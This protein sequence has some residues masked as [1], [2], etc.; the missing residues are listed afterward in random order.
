M[1]KTELLR[2]LNSDNVFRHFQALRAAEVDEEKRTI[3]LSFSSETP[4]ARS[5][6]DEVLGHREGE[7]SFDRL[8][9]G[10]A[11]LMDHNGRDQIGVVLK[12]WTQ[13]GIGRALVKFGRSARAQEIFQD[14]A[15]GIRT[16]ISV[17]Y[18]INDY[19]KT[20]RSGEAPLYRMNWSPYEISIVSVPADDSIGIGR[21][22]NGLEAALPE[23]DEKSKTVLVSDDDTGTK[24]PK[25][26]TKTQQRNIV[27]MAEEN[28]HEAT[29][30]IIALCNQFGKRELKDKALTEGWPIERVKDEILKEQGAQRIAEPAAKPELG[31]GKKDIEN[32]SLVRAINEWV[33]TGTVTGLEG[34]ASAAVM[35][36]TG[37]SPKG[38]FVPFDIQ[39]AQFGTRDLNAST[40]T[41]GGALVGT[42]MQSMIELLY[43]RMAVVGLGARTLSGLQ[44]NIAIPK[45][46]GGAIAYWLAEG[47]AVPTSDQ[48]FTQ[49]GMT[50][51]RLA[52][53]TAFTKQLLIQ[54]SPSV[55]ALVRSDLMTAL[56]LKKDKAAIDGSGING[57]PLGIINTAGV[58]SLTFGSSP[59][60]A[61]VV[62][63]ETKLEEQ[64]TLMNSP[65]YLVRPAV[66]GAWKTTVKES[67]TAQYLW[68]NN[69]VNGYAAR[70]TN[71]MP[72]NKVLY[73]DFSQLIIGDW[74]GMDVTVD[75]YTLSTSGKI[76]IVIQTLTDNAIRHGESF[77]YSTDD[78]NQ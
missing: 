50:P 68:M 61:K 17:G 8:N 43:N 63:F 42:Q 60:W 51:K 73:G 71:Q 15:D 3:E 77:V 22:L 59:T 16:K 39:N 6:G 1:N 64:N 31:M 7:F 26:E 20:E 32:Y 11:L 56:A 5:Y 12:A 53:A 74:D 49:I 67:G 14:V 38:F 13:D 54:S 40:F 35:K 69:E 34:E 24:E 45:M 46:N 62:E 28:K 70:S 58:Q 52:A 66:K 19:E 30:E 10:A 44:G 72:D 76:R 27:V 25:K 36:K 23:K 78:G 9:N 48:A 18:D 55:E 37:R 75:P 33:E 41:K 29:K 2:K 21:A 47:S 57:E 4:V 65:A